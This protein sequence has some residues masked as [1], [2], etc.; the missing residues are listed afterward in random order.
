MGRRNADGGSNLWRYL[1]IISKRT[2]KIIFICLPAARFM[3][4]KQ[5]E[6]SGD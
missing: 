3:D 2:R 6:K 1:Y 4:K 5:L